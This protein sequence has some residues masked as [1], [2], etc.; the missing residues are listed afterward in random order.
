MTCAQR[1]SLVGFIMRTI[2][3][4]YLAMLAG[5][6]I[7]AAA[8]SGLHAQETSSGAYG[9]AIWKTITLGTYRNANVMREALDSLHCRVEK[10]SIEVTRLASL[11][12]P[13]Y[14][15]EPTCELEETANEIIGR[16][17]FTLSRTKTEVDLVIISVFELG[18]DNH[19]GGTGA[20]IKDI[21]TRA[22]LLGFELCPPEVGPQ[23]RLQYLD[24][25]LGEVLHI[26]MQP[27]AKYDGELVDLYIE[28]N[29]GVLLL[30]GVNA[31][32]DCITNIAS[33]TLFVF[34]KPR[35]GDSWN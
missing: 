1:A 18:F 30:F 29:E 35:H 25:P 27:V 10:A 4:L 19:D 32:A 6:A 9:T 13:I 7:G 12:A 3:A 28:N 11:A 33:S 8:V 2:G 24:E 23:L 17:A 20:S 5:A 16:P 15:E 21:Y 14:R 22:E 26:A 31:R 34:V